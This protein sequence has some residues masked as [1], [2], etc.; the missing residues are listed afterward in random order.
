LSAE[1]YTLKKARVN[2]NANHFEY[3]N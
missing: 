2:Q 1:N 3:E